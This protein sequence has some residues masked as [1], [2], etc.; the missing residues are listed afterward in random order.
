[1]GEISEL[2]PDLEIGMPTGGGIWLSCLGCSL[3]D[4]RVAIPWIPH[5]LPIFALNMLFH[6]ICLPK[7]GAK[8]ICTRALVNESIVFK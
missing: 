7:E 8:S 5:L 4:S 1:M 6:F 2:H 3:S